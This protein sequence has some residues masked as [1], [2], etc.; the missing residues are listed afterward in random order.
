[1][2]NLLTLPVKPRIYILWFKSDIAFVE[3]IARK[4]KKRKRIASLLRL[5]RRLQLDDQMH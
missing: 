2:L 1:M 5:E 4:K 3:K